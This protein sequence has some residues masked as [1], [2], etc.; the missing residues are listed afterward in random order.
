MHTLLENSVERGEDFAASRK[1]AQGWERAYPRLVLQTLEPGDPSPSSTWGK[2]VGTEGIG[3][4]GELHRI[5]CMPG[6][7]AGMRHI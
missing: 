4:I 6:F 1:R 7:E 2:W 3:A 5:S